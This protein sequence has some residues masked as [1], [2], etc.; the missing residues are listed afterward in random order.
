MESDQTIKSFSISEQEGGTSSSSESIP[1]GIEEVLQDLSFWDS[2]T[3]PSDGSIKVCV[4]GS[5]YDLEHDDLPIDPDV[6]GTNNTRIDEDWSVDIDGHG[7][8]SAGTIAAIGNNLK[9]IRGIFPDDSGGKFKLIIAKAASGAEGEGTI[10]T[11]LLAVHSCVQEGAKVISIAMGNE[12]YSKIE[13]IYFDRLYGKGVLIVA[14]AGDEGDDIYSY[15]ATLP[16][17]IAVASS[18]DSRARGSSSSNDQIELT[19]P[20]SNIVS[21]IPNNKYSSWTGSGMAAA[22]VSA[23]AGLLWM[24]FPSCTNVQIRNVLAKT[25]LDIGVT[26]CDDIFGH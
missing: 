23:V 22:H 26:G 7:T 8:H 11:L 4:A 25:A 21:T 13:E 19:A 16:S 3:P 14:A 18:D 12:C 6:D 24:H 15:P 17:V 1:W 5:G 10:T 9:G 20:G 2:V